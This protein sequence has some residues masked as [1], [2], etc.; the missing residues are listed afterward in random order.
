MKVLYCGSFAPL[1][2]GHEYVYNAIVN[3]FG[4]ENVFLGIGKNEKK[5]TDIAQILY[6]ICPITSNVIVYEGLTSNIVKKHN[7]D[8]LVRGIRCSEDMTEESKLAYWNKE[9]CGVDTLFIVTSPEL[10]M[11]SSS[12]LNLLDAYDFGDDITKF[13]NSDVYY[14]YKAKKSSF[15]VVFGKCCSGKSTHI[16]THY[17]NKNIIEI[18]K[19]FWN[20]I[21][22]SKQFKDVMGTT[23]KTLFYNKNKIAFNE[24]MQVVMSYFDWAEL[25]EQIDFIKQIN[26]KDTI[27]DF[28]AIGCY[29]DYIPVKVRARMNLIKVYTK[30]ENRAVFA[31]NR[32]ANTALI[33]CSD[34]MYQDPPYHDQEFEIM[35]E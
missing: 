19:V 31:G 9:L 24:H 20:Y 13:I 23:L 27:V 2:K 12:A 29:W 32:N 25:E 30:E 5:N 4:K 34:L 16:K 28:P 6:S 14:R 8:Y 33:E 10:S 22:T 11:I 35:K 26:N 18:D 3:K 15:D 21:N 1:H 17:Q 7:F